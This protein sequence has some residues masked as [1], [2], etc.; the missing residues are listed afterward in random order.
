M[1]K[2]HRWLYHSTLGSRVIKKKRKKKTR[3]EPDVG[4]VAARTEL[5]PGETLFRPESGNENYYTNVLILL[6]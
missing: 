5:N 6:V 4:G 2:A 3:S 1:F